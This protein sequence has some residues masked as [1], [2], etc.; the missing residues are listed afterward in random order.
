MTTSHTAPPAMTEL[1]GDVIS[2]Y[3][4]AQAIEDG[5]LVDV[6]ETAREAGFRWPV[7]MTRAAWASYVEVPAGVRLQDEAGRLWDVVMMAHFGIKR[8]RTGGTRLLFQLHVRNDN[9][10]RTPPL[11]TLV[12]VTG[13]GDEGEPVITI[14][15][16]E[17]D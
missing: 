4:R 15:M 10:N 11:R 12:L 1:F 6:T 14:C 16:P 2:S 9:R 3:S 13:P 8:S 7:A 5:T 17:E